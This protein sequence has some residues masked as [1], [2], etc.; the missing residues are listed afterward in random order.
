MDDHKIRVGWKMIVVLTLGAAGFAIAPYVLLDSGQS[1]V[2]LS[3]SFSLHYPLL[4]VH[5]FASFIAL[6]IGWLQF[7]PGLRTKR[8]HVH[9]R[10][11][12]FYL[13]F[14]AIG[15]IT[16]LVVGMY[17]SSYIRQMAFLTLVAFWLFTGWKGY[18]TARKKRFEAHGVWMIRN[19]AVTLVAASARL[20]TPLCILI[21]LT[22]H[23][24]M[25]FQGFEPI[26]NQVLEVNIWVGLVV[27]VII[28][29]WMIVNRFKKR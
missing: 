17:T 22:L 29:E 9:R 7:L 12:R 25:S 19:Y 14:V 18:R 5:I 21:Y 13:G 11:G 16:G 20:V 15:S 3:A 1:R 2:S 24:G 10:V 23:R 8:P 26:L 28:A 4:L 27:N 6:I